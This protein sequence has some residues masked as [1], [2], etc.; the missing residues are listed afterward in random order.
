MKRIIYFALSVIVAASCQ[1]IPGPAG[2][3]GRDGRDGKDGVGIMDK[4]IINVKE[5]MWNYSFDD[6]NAYFYAE[7][8]MSDLI[9]N[10]VLHNSLIKMFRVYDYDTNDARQI[11]MPYV[12]PVE[13]YVEENIDLG[14]NPWVFYTETV[15]YEVSI[16][17]IT[18]FYTRGDF[19]YELDE[20]L[21]PEEMQFKYYIIY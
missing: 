6:N 3:D 4:G 18:I 13:R 10:S 7:V 21:T 20:S 16:G 15:D 2:R 1:G 8:D 5:N 17:K 9:T 19:E 11:E 12:R 14:Y